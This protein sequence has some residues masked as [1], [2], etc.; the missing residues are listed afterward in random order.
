MI[1]SDVEIRIPEFLSKNKNIRE[2]M[3]QLT[4]Y[5]KNEICQSA[6]DAKRKKRLFH[7]LEEICTKEV[8][9]A[10]VGVV[11]CGKSS[12]I[13]ALYACRSG[14][15]KDI[16]DEYA[17]VE[18]SASAKTRY[19]EKYRIGNLILWDT[20]GIDDASDKHNLS[21]I[22]DLLRKNGDDGSALIDLVL[23][24][25]EA[26]SKDP[27]TV[28]DMINRIISPEMAVDE[29]R[30]LVALNKADAAMKCGRHWDYEN[31]RPDAVLKKFLKKKTAAVK[32]R[33]FEKTGIAV[34]PVYYCA[35]NN[36]KEG[37]AVRPYNMAKLF[38]MMLEAIPEK[39]RV[40]CD[41]P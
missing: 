15:E 28:C 10:L 6:L 7:K 32:D 26:F 9:V 16:P 17:T 29:G 25:V 34:D 1:K 18:M 8:N 2:T 22:R 11:G 19:V 31:N 5:L 21:V 14:F 36:A 4:E 24:I 35:G 30:I 13:N 37:D 20:P 33:I 12:T 41:N 3:E 23:V 40:E 38:L 27:E 39:K